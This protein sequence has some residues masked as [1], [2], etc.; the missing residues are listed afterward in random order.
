MRTGSRQA[1]VGD[2]GSVRPSEPTPHVRTPS[3]LSTPVGPR[4]DFAPPPGHLPPGRPPLG[5]VPGDETAPPTADFR[6][7]AP[8][9]APPPTDDGSRLGLWLGLGGGG[10]A[11]V[12]LAVGVWAL[13][14]RD[15]GSGGGERPRGQTTTTVDASAVGALPPCPERATGNLPQ[16]AAFG[17]GAPPTRLEVEVSGDGTAATVRWDDPNAGRSPYLV[18]ASCD[19]PETDDR[20]AVAYVAAGEATEVTVESLPLEHNYCFTVGVLQPTGTDAVAYTAPDGTHF[21]CLDQTT[22]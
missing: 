10:V 20:V 16:G 12:L 3:H 9:P 1:W 14:I 11:V 17:Q 15:D 6:P 18:Y 4:H 22:R 8:R 7:P 5:P 2:P 13:L 19:A 21:R